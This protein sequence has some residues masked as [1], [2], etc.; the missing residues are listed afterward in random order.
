MKTA[1]IFGA[2]VLVAFLGIFML[3]KQNNVGPKDATN[4]LT[5]SPSPTVSI[6]SPTPAPTVPEQRRISGKSAIIKTDKGNIEVELIASMAAKTVT[7]FATLA[8]QGY[9]NNLTFH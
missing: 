1:V 4:F 9:Y 3:T 8:K 2:I 7:N 6:N 5:P